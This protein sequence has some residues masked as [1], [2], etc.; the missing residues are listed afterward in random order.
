MYISHLCLILIFSLKG[1]ISEKLKTSKKKKLPTSI[2]VSKTA[3]SGQSESFQ[4]L[5][6]IPVE[7]SA[8]KCSDELVSGMDHEGK[9]AP[10]EQESSMDICESGHSGHVGSTAALSKSPM[11]RYF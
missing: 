9:A 11:L 8:C 5:G 2:F 10:N 3:E 1:R 4:N 7:E 6:T